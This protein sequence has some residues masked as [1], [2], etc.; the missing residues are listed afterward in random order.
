VIRK[1]GSGSL[2]NVKPIQ[3]TTPTELATGEDFNKVL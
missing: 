2:A 3:A 1:Q